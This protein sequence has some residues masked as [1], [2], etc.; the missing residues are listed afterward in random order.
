[1]LYKCIRSGKIPAFKVGK[2]WRLIEKH[3]MN[4]LRAASQQIQKLESREIKNETDCNFF[5]NCK[6][7]VAKTSSAINIG[8]GL[9]LLGKKVLLIT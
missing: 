1:M 4:G 7:G 2:V 6:G 5:A 9:A 8:A 3:F